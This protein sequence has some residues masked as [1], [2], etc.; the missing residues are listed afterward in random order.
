MRN[1]IQVLRLMI[2]SLAMF[3]LVPAEAQ[4]GSWFGKA[5]R[6]LTKSGEKAIA[7]GVEEGAE[8]VLKKGSRRSGTALVPNAGRSAGAGKGLT[9]AGRALSPVQAQAFEQLLKHL[10][11]EAVETATRLAVQYSDDGVRVMNK[12]GRRG[13]YY[14]EAHGPSVSQGL[15]AA[16]KMGQGERY[17]ELLARYGDRFIN[18]LDQHKLL[19]AGGTAFAVFLANPQ[20]FVDSAL[21]VTKKTVDT[22]V[23]PTAREV[24]LPVTK[25]VLQTGSLTT[26][27]SLELVLQTLGGFGLLSILLALL[28]LRYGVR[29]ARD[30]IAAMNPRREMPESA[31]QLNRSGPETGEPSSEPSDLDKPPATDTIESTSGAG[32]SDANMAAAPNEPSPR[33]STAT[34][35]ALVILVSLLVTDVPIQAGVPVVLTPMPPMVGRAKLVKTV[36]QALWQVRQVTNALRPHAEKAVKW[37]EKCVLKAPPPVLPNPLIT[38]LVEIAVWVVADRTLGGDGPEAPPP[39]LQWP[40]ALPQTGAWTPPQ[41]VLDQLPEF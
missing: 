32:T 7:E 35:V 40:E 11:P 18:H 20:P 1:T 12:L 28:V 5:V 13:R 31:R 27:S 24:I 33:R 23:V 41:H 30:L 38:I 8:Q 17:L 16:T 4:I 14:L 2:V 9:R 3:C 37:V 6:G 21:D 29:F 36:I 26:L 15:R 22:V 19:Y 25:E 10:G 34:G 39:P